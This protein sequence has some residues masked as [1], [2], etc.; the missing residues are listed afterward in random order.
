[1]WLKLGTSLAFR[2][3]LILHV[4]LAGE[5]ADLLEM[6]V[7]RGRC[8]PITYVARVSRGSRTIAGCTT[9]A[10]TAQAIASQIVQFLC[11]SAG[12]RRTDEHQARLAI[13]DDR[14]QGRCAREERTQTEARPRERLQRT[15]IGEPL[16]GAGNLD[17]ALE[18]RAAHHEL[19]PP[20]EH[21]LAGA[22]AVEGTLEC[23]AS[24]T[25]KLQGSSS[26]VRRRHARARA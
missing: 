8:M 22:K 26:L 25:T 20:V 7:Q 23:R 1:M 17:A 9:S 3:H 18:C 12:R 10:K 24:K 6:D 14:L 4:N 16:H 19:H 5:A 13:P 15:P 2:S 11:W 21:R